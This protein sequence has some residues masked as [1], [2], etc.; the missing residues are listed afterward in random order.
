MERERPAQKNGAEV[1]AI[2]SLADDKEY[3]EY[4][5][6]QSGSVD[7]AVEKELHSSLGMLFI[8][9][10]LDYAL[11]AGADPSRMAAAMHDSML[12]IMLEKLV[13]LGAHIE[14]ERLH[15]IEY[16][17]YEIVPLADTLLKAGLTSEQIIE[18]ASPETIN[19]SCIRFL[20]RGVDIRAFI[21]HLEPTTIASHLPRIIS[22]GI[23]LDINAL[24]RSI[25]PA[26]VAEQLPVFIKAGA[27]IDV[28]A[29]FEGLSVP[30]RSHYLR[31]FLE[32]GLAVDTQ[33]LIRSLRP[34]ERGSARGWL[35]AAGIDV[36]AH[37]PGFESKPKKRRVH[38]PRGRAED[39]DS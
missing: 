11:E 39:G 1:E 34:K 17:S 33:E 35:M 6:Q 4:L 24:H 22:T 28:A 18:K 15:G 10:F 5:I 26:L 16:R 19:N 38:P 3:Y 8:Y 23:E 20:D 36:E 13:Q 27:D 29:L 21:Q 37:G 12:I 2:L 31:Q 7:A 9:D 25:R 30:E 32:V 14:T